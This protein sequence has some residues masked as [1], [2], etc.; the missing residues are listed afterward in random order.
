MATGDP[1]GHLNEVIAGCCLSLMTS[2]R[3]SSAVSG[4]FDFL[5]SSLLVSHPCVVPV[6]L[7]VYKPSIGSGKLWELVYSEQ[8]ISVD[9]SSY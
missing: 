2:A 4:K 7:S 9:G 3:L 1:R 5:V 8:V 6:S